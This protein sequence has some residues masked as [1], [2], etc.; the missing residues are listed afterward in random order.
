M[1]DLLQ[2][3]LGLEMV[4]AG[5]LPENS[6]SEQ[7]LTKLGFQREGLRHKAVWHEGLDR[8]VDLIYFYRDR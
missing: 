1:L 6:A 7:L 8:P 3:Q 4:T 2:K 5:I